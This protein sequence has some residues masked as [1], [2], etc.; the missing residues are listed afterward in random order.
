MIEHLERDK[1][2][3]KLWNRLLTYGNSAAPELVRKIF[4]VFA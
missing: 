2:E 3:F 1:Y 4:E